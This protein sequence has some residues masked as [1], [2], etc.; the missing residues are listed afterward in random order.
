MNYCP[1]AETITIRKW[2]LFFKFYRKIIIKRLLDRSGTLSFR[3]IHSRKFS[4]S[5]NAWMSGGP[6]F[7]AHTC[8]IINLSLF[9]FLW[10]AASTASGTARCRTEKLTGEQ[11]QVWTERCS[12]LFPAR[13]IIF[14]FSGTRVFV[15]RCCQ[16]SA[17]AQDVSNSL[18][19]RLSRPITRVTCVPDI[20]CQ[21][22]Q[23]CCFCALSLSG[24]WSSGWTGSFLFGPFKWVSGRK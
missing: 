7:N 21:T 11:Q 22:H 5:M 12:D 9:F 4:Y 19:A 24:S 17:P 15:I 8:T 14:F 18:N 1:S 10:S 13:L 16:L 3:F 20:N 23:S 6:N 2:L